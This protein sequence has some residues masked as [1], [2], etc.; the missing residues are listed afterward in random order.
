MSFGIARVLSKL[1]V[2]SRTEAA[3]LVLAGRVAVN[4]R[5]A[6]DPEQPA[7]AWRDKIEVD[8]RPVT[9]AKPVY[10][11]MHKPA[12]LLTTA[13]DPEGRPTVYTLLP[14]DLDSWVFPVGRLD[15]PTSGLLLFTNDSKVGDMLTNPEIGVPKTYE[16]KVKG[17]VTDA[18]LEALKTGV[19]LDDG[20]V[21]SPAQCRVLS[22]NPGSTWLELTIREGK[23]RQVRRMGLAI[24]HE[25]AKLR[26]TRV[27]PVALG[28]LESGKCRPLTPAEVKAL[29]AIGKVTAPR[30]KRNERKQRFDPRQRRRGSERPR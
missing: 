28:E 21:T 26:R 22:S 7:D 3:D 25:V 12:G 9:G 18:E 24:G 16:V 17:Q 8:G 20:F 13:H 29:K 19:Q 1:G 6:R 5:P 14:P 11:A 23:N 27:G 4:G 2:A 10:L 30:V 15:G